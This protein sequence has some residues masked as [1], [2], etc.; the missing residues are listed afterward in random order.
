MEKGAV[1]GGT[2]PAELARVRRELAA[3]AADATRVSDLALTSRDLTRVLP[4][5]EEVLERVAE[6]IKHAL[7]Y[8]S[9]PLGLKITA[10]QG[11]QVH[12]Q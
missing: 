10:G 3:R 9:H 2:G 6:F 11:H 8:P 1:T 7:P 5:L 12:Q 4:L